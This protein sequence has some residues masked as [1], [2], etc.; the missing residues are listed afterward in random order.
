MNK[1][2]QKLVIKLG[3]NVLTRPDGH[4]DITNISHL[5]DQIMA[6]KQA[7]VKIVLVSSGAVAAG[8]SLL[9]HADKLD[10]VIRRQ[11]LSSIGQVRLMELYRQLFDSHQILCGQVLATKED[12]RDRMHYLHMRNC[13]EA[14]LDDRIIPIVNENDVISVTELMFTDNDELAGLVAAM[15]NADALIILSSVDGLY[16]GSPDAA[17]AKL[18]ETVDADDEKV[19]DFIAPVKSSFGR[20]GMATKIRMAQQTARLGADVI[21]ANGRSRNILQQ[22]VKGQGRCTRIKAKTTVSS[23][24]KWMAL[25]PDSKGAVHIN[26]GAMS[27][28]F[29][30]E[31]ISSLLPLGLTKVKGDFKK[32]DIIDIVNVEGAKI[33]VGIAQYDASEAIDLL[34]MKGQKPVVHYDYLMIF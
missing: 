34:G 11:M 14:L 17:D 3:S 5:V 6:L 2:Y 21:L 9:S 8:R 13:F 30:P 23:I 4:L 25:H 20:G 1:N 12:F 19:F 27:A 22:L 16:A 33:G 26:K 32:G 31:N 28:L 24:K 29:N 7:G 15:I 18:I 10:D